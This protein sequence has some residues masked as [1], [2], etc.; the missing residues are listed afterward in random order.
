VVFCCIQSTYDSDEDDENADGLGDRS[1]FCCGIALN[2]GVRMDGTVGSRSVF[3][4]G[5]EGLEGRRAVAGTS[6]PSRRKC[7]RGALAWT[8]LRLIFALGDCFPE[9]LVL[10][11]DVVSVWAAR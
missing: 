10:L 4:R 11:F 7:W 1:E 5:E 6:V 2:D 9:V 3:V 8:L